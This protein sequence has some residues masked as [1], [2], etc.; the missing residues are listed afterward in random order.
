M[1]TTASEIE[2]GLLGIMNFFSEY[3]GRPSKIS[4]G[5]S[6]NWVSDNDSIWTGKKMASIA[7][8]YRYICDLYEIVLEKPKHG[9]ELREYIILVNHK[10]F[11]PRRISLEVK[12]R[13]T[14]GVRKINPDPIYA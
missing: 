8:S 12:S 13:F 9:S 6:D 7:P 4:L 11:S 14:R 3:D 10:R 5:K 1:E 2:E